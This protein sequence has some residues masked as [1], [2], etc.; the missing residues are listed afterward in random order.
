MGA[1]EAHEIA[2]MVDTFKPLNTTTAA[3]GIDDPDSPLSW[4]DT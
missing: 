1:K 2:V 4:L 3:A